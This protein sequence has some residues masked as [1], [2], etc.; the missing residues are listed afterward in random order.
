MIQ[1]A[2]SFLACLALLTTPLASAQVVLGPGAPSDLAAAAGPGAGAIT[3]AWG[4]ASS[5]TGV[6]EYRVYRDGALVASTN[7]STT[8][9]TDAGLGHGVTHTYAVT[10]VDLLGEGPASEPATATTFA[11]PSEPQTVAASPGAVGTVGEIVVSWAAP[12]SDGGLPVTS[13]LVYRDGEL[14]ATVGADASAWTDA[15]LDLA[16]NYVYVVSAAN[17]AGEGPHSAA[18]CSAASPWGLA[19]GAP[20]CL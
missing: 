14:V 3:L 9:F 20:A 15:G 11:P 7:A 12:A 1:T 4:A 17:D 5:V 19:P 18:T 6:T 2:T 13:Y 10:A 8:S 16:R